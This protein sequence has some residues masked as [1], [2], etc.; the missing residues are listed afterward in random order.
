MCLKS[1]SE[2]IQ[3]ET[4]LNILIKTYRQNPSCGLAKTIN[5]Y[6]SR[7]LHHDELSFNGGKRCDYLS[8]QKY[9]RWQ[10]NSVL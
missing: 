3:L 9:W 2:F 6:L 1:S 7:L 10:V 4:W 5:Y 8:M